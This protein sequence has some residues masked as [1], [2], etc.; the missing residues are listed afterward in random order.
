MLSLL[1]DRVDPPAKTRADAHVLL[2]GVMA[3]QAELRLSDLAHR[4]RLLQVQ[5]LQSRARRRGIRSELERLEARMVEL[6]RMRAESA[7]LAPARCDALL[8]FMGNAVLALEFGDKCFAARVPYPR[9]P[10]CVVR[11][12]LLADP[13]LAARV[14]VQP[15]V[16]LEPCPT[17]GAMV[18][19]WGPRSVAYVAWALDRLDFTSLV[20]TMIAYL[21]R[22]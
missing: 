7:S 5:F 20:L 8:R 2:A 18:R 16:G 22:N 19:C 13:I 1:V 21:A 10:G 4:R 11:V 14:K 9:L 3:V 15:V 6:T 17:A 12:L